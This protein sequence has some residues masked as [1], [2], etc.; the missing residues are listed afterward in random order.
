VVTEESCDISDGNTWRCFLFVNMEAKGALELL[1]GS[2]PDGTCV[3]YVGANEASNTGH[4][5]YG[6][7]KNLFL[8]S[9]TVDV[10]TDERRFAQK[11]TLLSISLAGEDEAK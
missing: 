8:V 2:K 6:E 7:M 10:Q 9:S 3:R 5:L 11:D 4:V 1:L